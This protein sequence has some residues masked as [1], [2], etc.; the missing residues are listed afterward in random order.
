MVE[1]IH[2]IAKLFGPNLSRDEFC[3]RV[4]V[5]KSHLS[6]VLQGKRGMSYGLA[7]RIEQH[8]GP[9]VRAAE[10]LRHQKRLVEQVGAA[11]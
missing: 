2:P 9:K 11:A 3:E 8:F 4:D 10:L 5:S 7:E 1:S 6:L